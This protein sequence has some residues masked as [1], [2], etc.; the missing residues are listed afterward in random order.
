VEVGAREDLCGI[1]RLH[2]R[3]CQSV[4]STQGTALVGELSRTDM[5]PPD[6]LIVGIHADDQ[7][8]MSTNRE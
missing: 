3:R 5:K 7:C 8:A 2:A 6:L 4:P 1:A